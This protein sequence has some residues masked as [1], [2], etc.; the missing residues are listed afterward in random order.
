MTV[1]TESAV[2]RT[3]RRGDSALGEAEEEEG[4]VTGGA[5][6]ADGDD[7]DD[8]DVSLCA[9]A[10]TETGAEGTRHRRTVP[11]WELEATRDR[12]ALTYACVYT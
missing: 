6:S 8:D 2:T 7:D 3:G 9:E 12:S 1:H 11:S 4:T 10:E 5:T